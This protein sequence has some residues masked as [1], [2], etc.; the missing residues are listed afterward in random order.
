MPGGIPDGLNPQRHPMRSS[1]DRQATF[2]FP[3]HKPIPGRTG[4]PRLHPVLWKPRALG[5]ILMASLAMLRGASL[6]VSPPDSDGWIRLRSSGVSNRVQALQSSSDLQ[7]W[8]EVAVFHDGPFEF[9]E[10]T[11]PARSTRFF[12]VAD[13]PRTSDDDGRNQVQTEGDPFW[14][15]PS[16]GLFETP[17]NWVKLTLLREE[18]SRVWF[19]DSRK[20]PFHHDYAKLR[21][22]PFLGMT[23]T[24]FDRRTLHAAD[25]LAILGAVLRPGDGRPEYGIQFVGQDAWAP[26]EVLAW[27]KRVRAAVRAPVGTQA[28]YMPTPEQR[29]AAEARRDWFAAA[30]FPVGSIERWLTRDAIYSEGW[31]VGR[32]S[33]VPSAEITAAFA[34]GALRSTDILL[35]DLVPAELPPLAGILTL[36]PAT[37]NSHVAL[38]A[39]GEGI[40]FVWF[41]DP[42]E[43][44]RLR[45]LAG[46]EVALRTQGSFLGSATVLDLGSGLPPDI[47]TGLADLR[48]PRPIAYTPKATLG[49]IIHTAPLGPASVRWVGGKAAHYGLLRE[50]IPSNSQPA[51]ALTFDLWDRFLAQDLPNGR[52][53]R[54]EIEAQLAGLGRNPE[55]ALVRPRLESLRTTFTREARFSSSDRAAVL[56]ALAAAGFSPSRKLRFRSSTNV[57]DGEEFTGAG[58][59]DS[60]SG[61]LADD[62]DAD[63]RGPCGCD[64]AE[65]EERGVFRAIQKVYASFY[66]ENAFLERW[67]RGVNESEVGMAVLVHPSFPDEIEM[68]NGV[69][70]LDWESVAGAISLTGKL[71]SQVGAESITNPDSATRPEVVEFYQSWGSMSLALR[72]SSSRVP[73]GDHAMPW[74]SEYRRLVGLL[75]SVARRYAQLNPKKSRFA[76]DFEYKRVQ[77]GRLE[78]KQVRP[79]PRIEDGA[80]PID[81]FLM[82][83]EELLVV[84][85]GEFSS[86]FAKHRLKCRLGLAT[87]ARRLTAV[88]L[89]TPPFR[90]VTWDA[91]HRGAEWI[92]HPPM[93]SWPGFQHS[94]SQDQTRDS[95]VVGS[96][97]QRRRLSLV[98]QWQRSITPPAAAWVTLLDGAVTLEAAYDQAQPELTWEGPGTTLSESVRMVPRRPVTSAALPQRRLLTHASGVRV[99]TRFLWP[100]EPTGPSA[101]YTAPNIGFVETTLTGLTRE[102]IVLRS[103]ASQT[104][105]PGH[106]NFSET[107]LFEPGL[108]PE[109]PSG[110]LQELQAAGIHQLVVDSGIFDEVRCWVVGP[111]GKMRRL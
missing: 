14:V 60:F 37:P 5:M 54:A 28:W 104:Y 69:A 67:R 95:W 81:A 91:S 58:L 35:T 55:V 101:G 70:T 24:E 16:G 11:D 19:Q 68:A 111:D 82:P 26:E 107:F 84:E 99:E 64:P 56:D 53:L 27:L 25:N 59:Y 106:H 88:G 63:T 40:P 62:L 2:P 97:G 87:E 38:L 6:E 32:L 74:E 103:G 41:A 17:V 50:A 102:P 51:I 21:L 77:P 72:Q 105:S 90:S 36:S 8:R 52:T 23:R 33:W 71:V 109:V 1:P 78:L 10:V 76:L 80:P 61:C 7:A 18:A 30:G 66:N 92:L 85:E 22:P 89:A 9:S 49:S 94:L 48:R 73:L 15:S 110:C 65:P 98:V 86:V 29:A 34:S 20:H 13:R 75:D 44:E 46:R 93:T 12:R 100:P 4:G 31:A 39:Q 83:T 43:R 3:S 96:G 79:L 42:A 47:R 45:S 108:D 57:E